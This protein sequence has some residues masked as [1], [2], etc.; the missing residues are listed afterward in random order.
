[1]FY[2]AYTGWLKL[3]ITARDE[4]AGSR[5]GVLEIS[6]QSSYQRVPCLCTHVCL[7]VVVV[8]SATVTFTTCV[9]DVRLMNEASMVDLIV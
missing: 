2:T 8:S 7:L 5:H 4:I 1:M 6:M 9:K 3:I